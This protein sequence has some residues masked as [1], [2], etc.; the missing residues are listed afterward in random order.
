MLDFEWDLRKARLNAAKHG[1]TFE[2]ATT[3]FEDPLASTVPD[4]RFEEERFLTIGRSR[5]GKMIVVAHA[6]RGNITLRI[7]SARLATRRER[8]QYE[9]S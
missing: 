1:V 5:R 8:K 4:D 2:E 3:V 7:I 6:D 9:Q